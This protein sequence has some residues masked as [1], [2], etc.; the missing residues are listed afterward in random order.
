MFG[1]NFT[2][3]EVFAQGVGFIA[4]LV[5]ISSY[6]FKSQ[7]KMFGMRIGSDML[8]TV[9]Y[10]LLGAIVPA[11][12]V[13][14]A[15]CRT[16]LVVFAIPQYK[17]YI[18]LVAI[19]LIVLLAVFTGAG[20]WA[21]W[22]PAISALIYG[23]ANYYHEDYIKSRVCMAI[24]LMLW[25]TIGVVFGSIPEVVSSVIGLCSLLLGM[26]RHLRGLHPKP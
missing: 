19:S 12:A 9:H 22:L 24:G 3:F 11:F 13:A 1:F 23:L 5:S 8:W 7:R 20:Y 10:L 17:T 25:L 4:L 2:P 26:R 18:I 14:V 21:N 16:F 15:F 6:Q